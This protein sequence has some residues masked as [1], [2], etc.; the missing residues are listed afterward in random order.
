MKIPRISPN[1]SFLVGIQNRKSHRNKTSLTLCSCFKISV[2]IKLNIWKGELWASQKHRQWGK[3]IVLKQKY[4]LYSH[5]NVQWDYTILEK[6]ISW[7]TVKHSIR[8]KNISYYLSI[9]CSCWQSPSTLPISKDCFITNSYFS[10]F[11][12]FLLSAMPRYHIF[13]VC[14]E[15][16]CSLLARL[17]NKKEDGRE[18]QQCLKHGKLQKEKIRITLLQLAEKNHSFY[19]KIT[20]WNSWSLL[21]GTSI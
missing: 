20:A 21:H 12:S 16:T 13:R 2:C 1:T 14:F 7:G 19:W 17:F 8:Y 11:S 9:F 4:S 3:N 5:C 15:N 10:I 18:K 6:A